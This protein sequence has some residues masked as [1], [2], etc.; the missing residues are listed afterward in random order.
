MNKVPGLAVAALIGLVSFQIG[1]F[2]GAPVMLFALLIGMAFGFL[3]SRPRYAPGVTWSSKGLL[4]IGVALLGMRLSFEDILSLGWT[5]VLGVGGLLVLTIASSVV[6]AKLL[7]KSVAFGVLAGGAVAIC[8]ASAALAIAAVLP[9][10]QRSERDI[11]FTVAGVTSL[12][13]VAMVTYP[14]LFTSLGF[15]PYQAGF[16]IGATIH[17]VAQVVG[18]GYTLG[19]EAGDVAT[20]VKLQRVALLPLVLLAVMWFFRGQSG[21][22]IQLPWFLLGFFW[23]MLI[24]N[25]MPV[26]DWIRQGVDQASS[27]ALVV[28][29]SALGM[30]TSLRQMADLGWSHL[31]LIVGATLILLAAA[32]AFAFWHF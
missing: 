10:N 13:T 20:F 19:P 25:L 23:L 29:I 9:L 12:S 8:G 24:G 14:W 31:A 26:P 22:Q 7:G 2:Y 27:G 3:A 15:Q 28:A 11:L 32:I 1:Q 6:L 18:A 21:G 30:R 17:D 5:P 4:R 16:L